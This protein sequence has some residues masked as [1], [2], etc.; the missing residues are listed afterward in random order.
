MPVEPELVVAVEDEPV[1]V[2]AE[3]DVSADVLS[4]APFEPQPAKAT[5]SREAPRPFQSAL[6]KVC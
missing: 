2:E 4:L 6:C 5:P 1:E 3:P